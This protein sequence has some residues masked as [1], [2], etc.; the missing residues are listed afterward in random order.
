M[1]LYLGY[2]PPRVDNSQLYAYIKRSCRA[3]SD[4]HSTL[5]TLDALKAALGVARYGPALTDAD[6]VRNTRYGHTRYQNL[7]RFGGT[8]SKL[9]PR[10]SETRELAGL[11]NVPLDDLLALAD[12]WPDGGDESDVDPTTVGSVNN[13]AAD[14][15]NVSAAA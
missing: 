1:P 14:T 7:F 3:R 4:A 6:R 12:I 8:K 15:G 5:V 9:R 2:Q 11:L 10:L 13:N